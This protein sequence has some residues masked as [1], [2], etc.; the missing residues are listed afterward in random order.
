MNITFYV[1]A[2]LSDDKRLNTVCRLI[3]KAYLQKHQVWVQAGSKAEAEQLDELLWGF[4]P[5]SFVPHHL[6]GEGPNPPPPVRIAW[7]NI[8]PEAR[9]VLINLSAEIPPRPQQFQRILEI[10][11]G[12]ESRREAA[13]AHWRWYKQNGYAISSHN[14]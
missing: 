8:R 10:V 6:V 2:D 3:E 1:I 14:L 12:D 9:D 5:D 13:R 7:Q 4:K 11:G